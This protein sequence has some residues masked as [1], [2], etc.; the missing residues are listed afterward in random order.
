MKSEELLELQD[1]LQRA[2]KSLRRLAAEY[3]TRASKRKGFEV[4][5]YWKHYDRLEAKAEGVR[6]A[7]S[8]VEEML[9]RL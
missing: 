9:R 8:Y 1:R 3:E 4:I 6:L 2:D 5:D 7:L